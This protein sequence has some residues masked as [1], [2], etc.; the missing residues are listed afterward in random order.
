MS[1]RPLDLEAIK[2]ARANLDRIARENPHL[3]D[4]ARAKWTEE[5]IAVMIV[6]STK[7]T[8]GTKDVA[9]ILGVH[10]ETVRREINRGKLKAAKVGR[11]LVISKA[12]LADYYQAKGGGRLFAD[13][14]S[15]DP[16]DE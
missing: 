14:A 4:P 1:K 6:D 15:N 9:E 11:V 10:E 5:D 12:D 2:Q 8:Y 7:T 16:G 3:I 13:D